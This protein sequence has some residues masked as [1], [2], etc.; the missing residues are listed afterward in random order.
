MQRRVVIT[1]LGAITPIGNNL[2]DFWRALLAGDVG[3]GPITLFDASK[4]PTRIAAEVKGFSVTD[5][6]D[7]KQAR[8][9]SRG[10]QFAV[11][12]AGMAA[13]DADWV[14]NP[15]PGKTAL[16]TGISNSPQDAIEAAVEHFQRRG[17]SRSVPHTVMR[18]FTHSA[19]SESARVTGFQSSVTTLSTACS[20]GLNAVGHSLSTIRS[21]RADAVLC[22]GTDSLLAKY[23][24]AYFCQAGLLTRENAD[25]QHASRPFDAMR[26]GGVMGEGAG[27][28]MLE[29][30]EHARQRGARIYAEILGSG[31]SGI[32]YRGGAPTAESIVP[33]MV[34]AMRE[35][36]GMANCGP[37]ALDYVGCN[38]V[39]DVLLDAWETAALKDVLGRDA[40][41][42]PMS[43]IKAQ[44]GVPTCAAGTLQ[45][46]STVLAIHHG[47]LP[48]TRNYETPDPLCDLDYV[49]NHPRRNDVNRAMVIAHGVSGSD[50]CIVLGRY[51]EP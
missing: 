50:A 34:A 35:A 17:F 13:E 29:E 23:V 18:C 19:A 43:S 40:Y 7:R 1:G 10:A 6:I 3:I 45:L 51:R 22:I 44:I 32:G 31:T 2:D 26:T 42:I 4:Y 46:I 24:F 21:G 47:M 30:L 49:P 14:N 41:R 33:G 28:L 20:S 8:I 15:G 5:F 38:G 48:A 12:V 39:S 37:H 16:V 27:C 9:M 36:L 25:P 11:A